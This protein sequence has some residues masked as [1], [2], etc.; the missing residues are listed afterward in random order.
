LRHADGERRERIGGHNASLCGNCC[1]LSAKQLNLDLAGCC[2]N[3]T[4]FGTRSDFQNIVSVAT[5]S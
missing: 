4:Q 2:E 1:S 5:T 3:R